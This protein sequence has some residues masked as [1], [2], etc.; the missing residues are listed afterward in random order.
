MK[1]PLNPKRKLKMNTKKNSK[2][3][4]KWNLYFAASL[5]GAYMLIS[6][7]IPIVPVLAGCALAALFTWRQIVRKPVPQPARVR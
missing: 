2:M 6:H 3:N 4:S 1:F 7:G 5:L